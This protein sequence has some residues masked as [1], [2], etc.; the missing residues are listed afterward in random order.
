[1]MWMRSGVFLL[2]VIF[3]AGCSTVQ[4]S[5]DYDPHKDL[6]HYGT[7]QWKDPVQ[8]ATGDIRVDNPLLDGR[9]R[10]AVEAH[11]T[12]RN[13]RPAVE[14]PDLHLV[15]HLAIER[16]I[17]SDSYYSSVGVGRYHHPWYG[18]MGADTRVYQYDESRLTIDIR[19]AGTDAL[20]WRGVGVYRL[21]T[22]KTPAAADAAMQKTVDRILSQFP[23]VGWK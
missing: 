19:A 23:P 15:Y 17:Q 13:I 22:H 1:M 18:G 21:K 8:R 6:S 7:W 2:A 4:V 11:L 16:K 9:I 20:L 10:R 14:R 5:Q 3:M 12:G